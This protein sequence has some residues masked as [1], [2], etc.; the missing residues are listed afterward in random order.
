MELPDDRYI[1]S[2]GLRATGLQT[3]TSKKERNEHFSTFFSRLH[4][5][6]E[7]NKLNAADSPVNSSPQ[8]Y[9]LERK[10]KES[11]RSLLETIACP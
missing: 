3:D 2:A 4:N 9:G 5:R 6:T 7:S 10:K 11:K 1:T 8:T